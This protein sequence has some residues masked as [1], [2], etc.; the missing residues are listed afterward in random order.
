MQAVFLVAKE[1]L[2][3]KPPLAVVG[4]KWTKV[5][6]ILWFTLATTYGLAEFS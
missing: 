3:P 5:R 1:S 4:L 2:N 6:Q